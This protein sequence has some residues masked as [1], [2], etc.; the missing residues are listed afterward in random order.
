MAGSQNVP[1]AS[2]GSI[3]C[4]GASPAEPNDMKRATYEDVLNAPENKVAEILDDRLSPGLFRYS[5]ATSSP[6]RTRQREALTGWP[7]RAARAVR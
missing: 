3:D 4:S 6:V 5:T 7:V 1:A 2:A